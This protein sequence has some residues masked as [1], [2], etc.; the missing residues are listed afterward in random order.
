MYMVVIFFVVFIRVRLEKLNFQKIYMIRDVLQR[1]DF[2]YRTSW[3]YSVSE[4]V[5]FVF[6]RGIGIL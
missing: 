3:L 1:F 5:F 6:G 4:V 2:L